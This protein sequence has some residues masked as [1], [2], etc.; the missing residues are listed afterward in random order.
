[1]QLSRDTTARVSSGLFADLPPAVGGDVDEL[2]PGAAMHDISVAKK[3]HFLAV[4]TQAKT[5]VEGSGVSGM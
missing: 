5:G 4:R 2:H 1:M 3:M